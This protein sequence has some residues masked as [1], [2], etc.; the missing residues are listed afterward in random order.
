MSLAKSLYED[1]M[2]RMNERASDNAFILYSYAIFLARLG[3]NYKEIF[4]RAKTCEMKYQKR[5]ETY[6]SM[7][8]LANE[9]FRLAANDKQ[10]G[11]AW[12]NYA[13]CR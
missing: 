11:S 6:Q 1:C 5:H 2:N 12:H 10:S 7:Y 13:L 9:I 4:D 8:I 3:S